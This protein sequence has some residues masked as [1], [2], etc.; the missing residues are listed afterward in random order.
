MLNTMLITVLFANLHNSCVCVGGGGWVWVGVWV[1]VWGVCVCVC[2][3]VRWLVVWCVCHKGLDSL[4]CSKWK[5]NSNLHCD[6]DL[7]QM[8]NV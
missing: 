5:K 6:L 8:S 3:C 2:V 4:N 7:D 1:G